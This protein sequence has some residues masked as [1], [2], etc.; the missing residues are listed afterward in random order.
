[1]LMRAGRSDVC[2]KVRDGAAGDLAIVRPAAAAPPKP[3]N[4]NYAA[5]DSSAPTLPRD[6][7]IPPE[8]PE[9]KRAGDRCCFGATPLGGERPRSNG[10]P[11]AHPSHPPPPLSP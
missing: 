9:R 6:K 10:R 8:R 11:E 1:M 3:I 5:P 2:P 4:L 7:G